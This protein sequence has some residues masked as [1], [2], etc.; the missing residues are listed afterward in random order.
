MPTRNHEAVTTSWIRNAEIIIEINHMSEAEARSAAD[1][2]GYELSDGIVA[3]TVELLR[4]KH[5][6]PADPDALA[7]YSLGRAVLTPTAS[8]A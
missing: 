2:R 3:E 4:R 5:K 1:S 7:K 8:A 6:S